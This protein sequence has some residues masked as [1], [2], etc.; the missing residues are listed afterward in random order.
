M[1]SRRPK[2]PAWSLALDAGSPGRRDRPFRFERLTF[3][4]S[5]RPGPLTRPMRVETLRFALASCA[6]RERQVARPVYRRRAT[7]PTGLPIARDCGA[8]Q[9]LQPCESEQHIP[10][11]FQEVPLTIQAIGRCEAK[12]HHSDGS[13]S[14]PPDSAP[15]WSYFRTPMASQPIFVCSAM[16]VAPILRIPP[17]N[18]CD[19][20]ERA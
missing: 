20:R 7:R 13:V 17:R 9:H 10:P 6:V 2:H 12:G 8:R 18:P 14:P 5:N 4:P 1:P 16:Q 11:A 3:A 15:L 19:R